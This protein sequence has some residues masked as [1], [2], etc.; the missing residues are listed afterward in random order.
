[1]VEYALLVAGSSLRALVARGAAL[2]DR[3][4]WQLVAWVALAALVARLVIGGVGR[5]G[6]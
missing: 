5:R 1:M 4:D 2:A 3:I 6:R